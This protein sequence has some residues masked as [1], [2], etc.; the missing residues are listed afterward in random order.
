MRQR[1]ALWE[2]VRRSKDRALTLRRLVDE[3][4]AL[5]ERLDPDE[6]S[7]LRSDLAERDA[8]APGSDPRLEETALRL[9]ASAEA[10]PRGTTLAALR[11][12]VWCYLHNDLESEPD[13]IEPLVLNAVDLLV[14]SGLP[15]AEART[16][17]LA[18]VA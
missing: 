4:L 11:W 7:R 8:I 17:L 12:L 16:R 9:E 18:L 10:T 1:D 14:M 6:V 15:E 5:A 13:D 2:A 3:A